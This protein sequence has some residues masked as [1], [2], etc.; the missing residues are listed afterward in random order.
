MDWWLLGNRTILGEGSEAF[1]QLAVDLSERGNLISASGI[2]GTALDD[3]SK[4]GRIFSC[5][6][7]ILGQLQVSISNS[8][9]DA[10]HSF[11]LWE[12]HPNTNRRLHAIVYSIFG[13]AG[14]SPPKSHRYRPQLLLFVTFGIDT[15]CGE[16]SGDEKLPWK[17]WIIL[18]LSYYKDPY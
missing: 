14:F 13:W 10:T 11:S 5:F 7:W 1:F 15:F 2:S 6:F 4:I 9:S 17:I 12:I 8:P 16:V 18:I 3:W